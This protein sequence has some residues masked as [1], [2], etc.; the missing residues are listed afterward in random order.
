MKSQW[1]LISLLLLLLASCKKDKPEYVDS[2]SSSITKYV[3]HHNGGKISSY[4]LYLNDQLSYQT[5]FQFS[6]SI[7]VETTTTDSGEVVSK[8]VYNLGPDGYAASSTDSAFR[9]GSLSS[10]TQTVYTYDNGYL[11]G[12]IHY[13]QETGDSEIREIMQNYAWSS[14]NMSASFVTQ[15]GFSCNNGYDY[16]DIPNLMDVRTFSNG[17]TGKNSKNLIAH[18]SWNNGCPSGPSQ[19]PGYSD[20]TYITNANGYVTSMT[21][22]YTPPYNTDP[23]Y[24]YRQFSTTTYSYQP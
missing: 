1:L 8:C 20:F 22:C 6:D 11:V 7:V 18:A 24:I 2:Y 12:R 21:T 13:F 14:D 10:I 23:D 5:N 9:D 4:E 16:S 3:I 17:I 15:N 19:V